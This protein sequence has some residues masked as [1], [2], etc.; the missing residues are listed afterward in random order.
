VES[1]KNT[2]YYPPVD[3]RR[4]FSSSVAFFPV[5]ADSTA[6]YNSG[7]VEKK[8]RPGSPVEYFSTGPFFHVQQFV[9]KTLHEK[10]GKHGKRG[11][12]ASPKWSPIQHF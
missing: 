8:D 1:A 3:S 7:R 9:A 10:H 4:H 2:K 5:S 6:L 11:K 12:P